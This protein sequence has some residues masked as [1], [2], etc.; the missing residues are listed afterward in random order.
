M[1]GSRQLQVAAH[2]LD[3]LEL[4]CSH[5]RDDLAN[6]CPTPDDPFYF[7]PAPEIS[8]RVKGSMPGPR[9]ERESISNLCLA[10]PILLRDASSDALPWAPELFRNASIR[11]DDLDAR[12][13]RRARRSRCD[14]QVQANL[15]AASI[16]S[17]GQ[18][19]SAN[20]EHA[21]EAASSATGGPPVGQGA[22]FGS[23]GPR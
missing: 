6:N 23:R 12:R 9:G 1:R 15:A 19:E 21:Q 20:A 7:E 11:Q 13:R 3:T 2:L 17:A 10:G 16:A 18:C 22:R 5:L 4:E 14:S 8:V